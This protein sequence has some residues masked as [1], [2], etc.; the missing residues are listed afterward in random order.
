VCQTR[1]IVTVGR[2]GN[3]FNNIDD[4]CH[5]MPVHRSHTGERIGHLGYNKFPVISGYRETFENP[6]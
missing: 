6:A 2:L 1:L 3:A 4:A 5:R